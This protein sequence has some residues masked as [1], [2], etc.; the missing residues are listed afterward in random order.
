[1]TAA[2]A[3]VTRRYRVR[4]EKSKYTILRIGALQFDSFLCLTR[5]YVFSLQFGF[6]LQV[7]LPFFH[8]QGLRG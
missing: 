4:A 2:L 1:M 8:L 5:K 7:L 6:T 3:L